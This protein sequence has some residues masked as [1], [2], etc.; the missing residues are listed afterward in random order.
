MMGNYTVG[1]LRQWSDDGFHE[2]D[3]LKLVFN[4]I[5]R[6]TGMLRKIPEV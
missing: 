5:C 2:E 6:M 3:S 1:M 4:S